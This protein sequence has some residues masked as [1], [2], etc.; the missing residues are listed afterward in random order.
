MKLLVLPVSSIV[1][2]LWP[3]IGISIM[4]QA[5]KL[6]GT[7]GCSTDVDALFVFNAYL[8]VWGSGSAFIEAICV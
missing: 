4:T 6:A 8:N 7:S 2:A 5:H 1:R 3:S